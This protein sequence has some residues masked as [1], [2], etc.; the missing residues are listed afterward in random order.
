MTLL[1][2]LLRHLPTR[3]FASTSLRPVGK[4]APPPNVPPSAQKAGRDQGSPLHHD[5]QSSASTH[6]AKGGGDEHPA[7]QPDPQPAPERDTGFGNVSGSGGVAGGEEG[8]HNRSD[9]QGGSGD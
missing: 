8:L 3:T 5:A 7:R 9:R 6:E 2:H 4:Q 1:L